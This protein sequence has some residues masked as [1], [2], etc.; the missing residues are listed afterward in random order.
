MWTRVIKG[1]LEYWLPDLLCI[2]LTREAIKTT[3]FLTLARTLMFWVLFNL[4]LITLTISVCFPL[5]IISFPLFSS[6]YFADSPNTV[7]VICLLKFLLITEFLLIAGWLP[8]GLINWNVIGS[9]AQ[10]KIQQSTFII[11]LCYK[12][13]NLYLCTANIKSEIIYQKI[14]TCLILPN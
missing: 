13:I 8:F 14:R 11:P 1:D 6:F 2:C 9:P 4:V 10:Q 7:L 3:K 12:R 5:M